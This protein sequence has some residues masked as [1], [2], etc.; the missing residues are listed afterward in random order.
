[1]IRK[2]E[3]SDL[4]DIT[5]LSEKI[6]AF[7][8]YEEKF[9]HEHA[10]SVIALSHEQELMCVLDF[11]G[12][13]GFIGGLKSPSLGHPDVWVACEAGFWI[14]R[15]YRKYAQRLIKFM[16]CTARLAGIKYWHMSCVEGYNPV[17]A[18]RMYTKMNYKKVETSYLKV[19]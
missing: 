10:K 4:D 14:E 18:D 2:S 15:R 16:E 11:D 19:I 7:S 5:V 8:A 13:Q 17:L 9:D 6:W 12:L 3:L 1:M